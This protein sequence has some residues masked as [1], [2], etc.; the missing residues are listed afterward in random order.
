V[1]ARADNGYTGTYD[2]FAYAICGDP[3][4]SVV[5]LVVSAPNPSPAG[6]SPSYSAQTNACAQGT[7]TGVGGINTDGVSLGEGVDGVLMDRF[8]VDSS[9]TMVRARGWDNAGGNTYQ[10]TAFAI[11]AT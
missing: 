8:D 6:G 10:V 2:L 1:E 7:V 5:D 3:D 11:C 4:T 9:V